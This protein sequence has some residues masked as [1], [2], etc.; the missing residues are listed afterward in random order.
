MKKITKLFYL[1]LISV[2]GLNANDDFFK[3]GGSLGTFTKA[4]FNNQKA[5]TSAEIYPT[6]NFSSLFGE[7]NTSYNVLAFLQNEHIKAFKFG[8]GF[9]AGALI[10]DSTKNDGLNGSGSRL[11]NNYVGY[12]GGY[13]GEGGRPDRNFLVHNA[14]LDLQTTYFNIKGGRYES[15]MDYFSGY[16]QGFN[17]DTHFKY[18]D[19]SDNEIKIW[20]FSSFGRGF[21]YSQWFY[22]YYAVK[23]SKNNSKSYGIHAG[24]I[25]INYGELAQNGDYKNG[26][27]FLIRPFVYF[28]PGLY[29]APGL[30]FNY[31]KEFGNGYGIDLILQGYG[32]H[33]ANSALTKNGGNK[34]YDESVDKWSGNINAILRAN[35]FDYY[36]QIGYY[37]NFKSANSHFG[38][39]GNPLGFDYWT[40]SVYD[41]GASASDAINRNAKTVYLSG[42]GKH[43]LTYGDFGWEILGR[44]TYSPRS[45]EQSVALSLSHLFKNNIKLGLK[46]EW[47]RDVTKAGYNPGASARGS[48]ALSAK[49]ADDRSHAFLTFDYLF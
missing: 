30:K 15:S 24:G 44:L 42:G 32:L 39:Y 37:Q 28:Y 4:G 45:D 38:T 41:I 14:Y 35:I 36:A 26:D 3:I 16:T 34:R 2:V 47:F 10:M 13:L 48:T 1:G 46:I 23:T 40:A 17:V 7:V 49:R 18:G 20:W 29:Q 6:E 33:V 19:L 27:S 5:N 21:A 25:D 22:D 9:A 8:L 31:K 43:A 12:W 11:N